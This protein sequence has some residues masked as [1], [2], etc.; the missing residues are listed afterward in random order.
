MQS[1]AGC[2]TGTHESSFWKRQ[3]GNETA[4]IH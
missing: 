4:Q 3:G 1:W 2:I